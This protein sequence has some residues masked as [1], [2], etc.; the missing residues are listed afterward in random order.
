VVSS[1]HLSP[2]PSTSAVIK[3]PK[4]TEEN[5]G[6]PEAADEGDIQMEYSSD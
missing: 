5:P 4:N 2:T 3:T 6:D 1:D